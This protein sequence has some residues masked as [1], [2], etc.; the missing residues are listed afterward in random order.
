MI[1]YDAVNISECRSEEVMFLSRGGGG[2][3]TAIGGCT[4]WHARES[5]SENH[6]KR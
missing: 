1:N 4:R 3:V 5:P 6:P 2:G